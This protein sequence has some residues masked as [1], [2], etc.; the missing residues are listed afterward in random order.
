MKKIDDSRLYFYSG[1]VSLV[2][3]I[4][5]CIVSFYSILSVEP[6]ISRL[7]DSKTEISSNYAKAYTMLRDPQVFGPVSYTHL[8]AH[9]T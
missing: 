9:E 2:L 7:L 4:I 5:L 1:I 6:E 8:R 3:G